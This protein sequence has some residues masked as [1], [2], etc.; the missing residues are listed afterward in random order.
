ML[1]SFIVSE[2]KVFYKWLFKIFQKIKRSAS[3]IVL[4]N[5]FIPKNIYFHLKIIMPAT[6]SAIP[7]SLRHSQGCFSTP[8]HP[9]S[10]MI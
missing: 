2:S 3:F 10:S 1:I 5:Y 8:N 9:S 6:A 4:W 7:A